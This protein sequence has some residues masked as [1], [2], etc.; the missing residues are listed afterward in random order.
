MKKPMHRP[1]PMAPA[2][3]PMA[4]PPG[5]SPLAGMAQPPMGPPS[6]GGQSLAPNL[7]PQLQMLV[8]KMAQAGMQPEEIM[9]KLKELLTGGGQ[10]TPGPGA[11]GMGAPGMGAPGMGAPGGN[12]DPRMLAQMAAMHH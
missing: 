3:P 5:A 7:P 8:Q 10:G 11:P 4:G 12:M 2:P 9:A 6:G 1:A